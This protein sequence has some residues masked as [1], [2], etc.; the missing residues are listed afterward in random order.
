MASSTKYT[1]AALGVQ[2]GSW[3]PSVAL[4]NTSATGKVEWHES[5]KDK[6]AL[7]DSLVL[8]VG[9][10]SPSGMSSTLIS[11]GTAMAP[12]ALA[13]WKAGGGGG[14]G[15]G[16]FGGGDGGIGGAGGASR[17]SLIVSMLNVADG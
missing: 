17:A 9:G 7:L 13:A 12:A 5:S 4:A 15:G 6:P 1:V 3:H 2:S 10:T 8:A 14:G 11:V 16:S